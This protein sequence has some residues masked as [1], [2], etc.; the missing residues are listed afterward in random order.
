MQI[1]RRYIETNILEELNT[2]E[3]IIIN[4]PRRVGKT[5]LLKTI[6]NKVT[7]KKTAYFD[8]TDPAVIRLW[9]NFSQERI[10]AI[11]NDLGMRSD[12]GIIFFDE[13]QYL[14]NIGLLLKLFYDHFPGIKIIATGSSSFLFLHDI[15][16]S[17]A[18]RKKIFL[19]YP[20]SLEEIT[21]ISQNDFWQFEE[22]PVFAEK[23]QETLKKILLIGSYP[24]IY[25]IESLQGKIEKLKEIVDSYLFKDLL[26]V[27]GIKKPRTIVELTKLLALQIGNLV[28]PNEIATMLGISRR[29]VLN[30]IDLL[31]RFFIVFRVYPYDRNLRNVIK[32]K[33]KV[34][35]YDLGIRNAVIG[36]FNSLDQRDDKGFLLENAVVLG[37][38]RR[39]DYEK[40]LYEIFYWRN[41]EGKEVDIVLKNDTLTGIE[42]AWN[43]K[44]HKFTRSFSG[45]GMIV[46]IAD[47]YKFYL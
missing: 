40:K 6:K 28:N 47:A 29:T 19:L 2:P 18:G 25:L 39:I 21:E 45:K 26:M 30:Y 27:E 43:K 14:N 11:L 44:N 7:D 20:L 22:K 15:G 12:N 3:I 1:F 33:F 8:F 36:N 34:Y 17:L 37:L 23:L 31:E 13:I 9:Q 35:F 42:V 10:K 32:K 38:K 46:D 5:T 16:D 4:G 24:E 41:Y